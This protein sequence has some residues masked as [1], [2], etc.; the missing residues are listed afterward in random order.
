M[1]SKILSSGYTTMLFVMTTSMFRTI[2]PLNSKAAGSRTL[3]EPLL[4]SDSKIETFA[5]RA[6]G[7][8]AMSWMGKTS[9]IPGTAPL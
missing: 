5:P 6:G 1:D 9:L 4:A 8:S 3:E 2:P 7:G